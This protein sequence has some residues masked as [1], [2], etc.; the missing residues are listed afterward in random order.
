[1]GKDVLSFSATSVVKNDSSQVVHEEAAWHPIDY[2]TNEERSLAPP[3][4][5]VEVHVNGCYQ[6][7]RGLKSSM[8]YDFRDIGRVYT[9]SFIMYFFLH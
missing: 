1:M 8:C 2:W 7:V 9:G 4:M 6:K 3:I 5:V